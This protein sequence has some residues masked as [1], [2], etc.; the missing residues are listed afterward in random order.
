V[1][2][3][4]MKEICHERQHWHRPT[5]K[6]IRRHTDAAAAGN[7]NLVDQCAKTCQLGSKSFHVHFDGYNLIPFLKG[8]VKESPRQEFFYWSDDGDLF[9][10]RVRDWNLFH[11]AVSRRP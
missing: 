5:S 3:A 6:G 2:K 4:L 9:A 10:I 11:R 7:A 1:Q 8:E